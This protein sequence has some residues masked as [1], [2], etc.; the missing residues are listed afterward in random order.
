M[1]D[2]MTCVH[3][4]YFGGYKP[5]IHFGEFKTQVS[6]DPTVRSLDVGIMLDRRQHRP[7]EVK[8]LP[9]LFH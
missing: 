8:N 3:G 4:E 5:G 6:L 1:W 2:D 9:I 7:L